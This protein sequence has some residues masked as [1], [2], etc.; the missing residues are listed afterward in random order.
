MAQQFIEYYSNEEKI[1][2]STFAICSCLRQHASN[3][4]SETRDAVVRIDSNVRDAVLVDAIN[5]LSAHRGYDFGLHVRDLY[6]L[7]EEELVDGRCLLTVVKKYYARYM[8]QNSIV[9]SVLRNCGTNY[10]ANEFPFKDGT[11]VLVDFMNYLAQVYDYDKVFT[12]QQLFEDTV[13]K[14]HAIEMRK[15][16]S[17]LESTG[18]YNE[19]LASGESINAIFCDMA[20]QGMGCG[21][22]R[23]LKD[24]TYHYDQ[25]H[26]EL[27]G[28][29]EMFPWDKNKAEEEIYA[30]AYAYTKMEENTDEKTIVPVLCEKILEMKKR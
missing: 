26:R 30:M 19:L 14:E 5:Y 3:Y 10:V 6:T 15:L 17:F 24:G 20:A 13:I 22:G 7:N 8:F 21:F 9:D 28:R 16:R 1:P 29:T 12:L 23:V 11:L 18:K 2:Y 27:Y 4:I 25:Q